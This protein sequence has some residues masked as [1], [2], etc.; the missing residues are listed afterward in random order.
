VLHYAPTGSANQA[1]ARTRVIHEKIY[2]WVPVR[3]A[4]ASE[5]RFA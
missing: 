5:P 1:D 3:T 2:R 4:R